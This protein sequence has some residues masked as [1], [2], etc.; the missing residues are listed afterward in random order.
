MES[1]DT[2]NTEIDRIEDDVV[3]EYTT[4]SDGTFIMDKK[5]QNENTSIQ[6][7]SDNIIDFTDKDPFSQGNY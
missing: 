5:S 6:N 7:L 3:S 2:G 4:T 1:I